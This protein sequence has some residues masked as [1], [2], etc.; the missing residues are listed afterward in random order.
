MIDLD[1]HVVTE[2]LSTE[3]AFLDKLRTLIHV[4]L[5]PIQALR[6]HTARAPLTADKARFIFSDFEEIHGIHRNCTARFEE[7]LQS[8]GSS[9]HFVR[10]SRFFKFTR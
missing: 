8:K 5:L 9:K 6:A 2:L 3:K 4:F 1:S 7:F 10:C